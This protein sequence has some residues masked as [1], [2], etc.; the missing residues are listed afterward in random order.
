[1]SPTP[2]PARR[3]LAGLALAAACGLLV[4]C[5]KSPTV[6]TTVP[7]ERVNSSVELAGARITV[8]QDGGL[9]GLHTIGAVYGQE[10]RFVTVTR[11]ICSSQNPCALI[12]SASGPLTA[13]AARR[14][15]ER[16]AAEGFF[17]LREDYGITR[18]GADMITYTVTVEANGATKSVRADDGTM[19][20]P[21]A[22]VLNA[23]R[24]AVSA[25][26]GQ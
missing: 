8:E 13:D 3:H 17:S 24:V 15:F 6:G 9:G 26:R 21:L 7:D 2:L 20:P 19:P 22:S 4:A 11:R 12:D 5:N 23:F 18:G 1:M 16:V 25:G 10:P 14:V